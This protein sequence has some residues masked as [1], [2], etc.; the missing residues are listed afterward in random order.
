LKGKTL[1]A[2]PP[3]LR[4]LSLFLA[5]MAGFFGQQFEGGIEL[6]PPAFPAAEPVA[7]VASQQSLIPSDSGEPS[8][9]VERNRTFHLL[10]K[11]DNLTCYQQGGC[12]VIAFTRWPGLTNAS[13]QAAVDCP[14]VVAKCQ[15]Y[16]EYRIM[17]SGSGRST[18]GRELGGTGTRH[19]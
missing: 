11:P 15:P 6:P 5:R 16:A 8:L 9:A 3:D 14:R 10:I 12:N 17:P 7:Q 13:A 1:E 2:L 4:D 18:E 19:N